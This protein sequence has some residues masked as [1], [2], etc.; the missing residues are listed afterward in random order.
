ME[1]Y[2]GITPSIKHISFTEKGKI[3]VNLE[4]GRSL[5]AP[6]KQFSSL[7]KLSVADRKKFTIGNGTI[8]VFDKCD[9]VYHLQDFFGLPKDYAYKG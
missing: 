3:M 2:T 8:I 1:G 9:E 7:S 4:D 6:V 5:I